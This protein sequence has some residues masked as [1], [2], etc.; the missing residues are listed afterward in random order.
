[1]EPLMFSETVKKVDEAHQVL[2]EQGLELCQQNLRGPKTL[3]KTEFFLYNV[4]NLMLFN[5]VSIDR[6]LN[7]PATN[8]S[9][10]EKA[11]IKIKDKIFHYIQYA[12]NK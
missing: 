9:K 3:H 5:G 10:E 1:M 6:S 2:K 8:F 12:N 4:E 7:Q 11:E